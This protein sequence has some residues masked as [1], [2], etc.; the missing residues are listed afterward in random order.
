MDDILIIGN[1]YEDILHL[2]HTLREAGFGVRVARSATSGI[3]AAQ[4]MTPDLVLLDVLLP[5]LDG[6]H[7]CLRLRAVPALAEVPVIF[8]SRLHDAALKAQAFEAGAEDFIVKPYHAKE[9]VVRVQH[10]LELVDLRKRIGEAARLKERQHIAR[11]L[12]DSVSQTLFILNASVQ[13][14]LIGTSELPEDDQQQLRQIQALSQSA[15]AEMRTLLYELR[16]QRIEQTSLHRLLHQ[17][18]DS[19][20]MRISAEIVVVADDRELPNDIKYVFY[21]VA[22]EALNNIAKHA[23]AHHVTVLYTAQGGAHHLVVRDD[24]IG[25]DPSSH[26]VGMGLQTMRERADER[27]LSFNVTSAEGSGTEID[28]GWYE[29]SVSG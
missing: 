19:F 23:Q 2:E 15:L 1:V 20:R 4:A 8:V 13:S 17:L 7:A 26:G 14:L 21:R 28:V 16:P 29:R 3:R 10:Q 5:D 9:V 11:E 27:Q 25:F 24:G 6:F 18:A 22:Q 12:H